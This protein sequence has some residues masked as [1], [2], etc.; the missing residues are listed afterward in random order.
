MAYSDFDLIEVK[1]ADNMA[2]L[3]APDGDAFINSILD[4][5]LTDQGEY[6]RR[7]LTQP[8]SITENAGE[9]SVLGKS[10]IAGGALIDPSPQTAVSARAWVRL[11]TPSDALERD[12]RA[13]I[14]L[15]LFKPVNNSTHSSYSGGWELNLEARIDVDGTPQKDLQLVLRGGPKTGVSTNMYVN[16]DRN[17]LE[18]IETGLS[19]NTWYQIRLDVIPNSSTTK[20]IKVYRFVGSSWNLLATH[21]S[22][23]G[24]ADWPVATPSESLRCG[25]TTGAI[26]K[27][28]AYQ[29]PEI[30]KY[31]DQFKIGVETVS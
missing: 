31:I 10:S 11:G 20:T 24:D 27:S 3:N 9:I 16:L 17:L 22:H 6:C 1:T 8:G 7:F 21:I 5:P 19:F 14:G 18:T 13:W 29:S 28:G 25:F 15:V 30:A 2:A 12:W 26:Q 23:E 4:N